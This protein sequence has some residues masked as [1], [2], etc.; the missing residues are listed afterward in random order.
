MYHYEKRRTQITILFRCCHTREQCDHYK[1]SSEQLF[2]IT[3]DGNSINDPI[4]CDKTAFTRCDVIINTTTSRY[5]RYLANASLLTLWPSQATCQ[6]RSEWTLAQKML[7]CLTAPS[8][9][10]NN[11]NWVAIREIPCLWPQNILVEK[12]GWCTRKILE[13]ICT[14]A[15]STNDKKGLFERIL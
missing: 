11:V 3:Q 2:L 1:R 14:M 5:K 8:Q 10:P 4:A 9:S 6:H 15:M 12:M 7:W 13:S